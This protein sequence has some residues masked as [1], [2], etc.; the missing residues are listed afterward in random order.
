MALAGAAPPRRGDPLMLRRLTPRRQRTTAAWLVAVTSI[1][2]LD[3]HQAV[4]DAN[5]LYA[6]GKYEDAAAA[7]NAGLVDQPDSA[8]LHFNLGDA[9]YKQGKYEDS[10][11]SFQK[12]ETI[13]DPQRA[14]R[15]AYN[16]GN[17]SYRQGQAVEQTDPQKALTLYAEALAAYR[18]A[19][20]L[21]PNDEDSKFNHELV[22]KRIE[23]LKKKLAE[24][25]KEQEP[26]QDQQQPQDDQQDNQQDDQQKDQQK[27]Q[28]ED[29]QPKDD[30]QDE[31]PPQDQQQKDQQQADQDQKQ[32]E[33]PPA[34]GD[35]EDQPPPDQKQPAEPSADEQQ[36]AQQ[37]GENPPPEAVAGEPKDGELSKGEAAAILDSQRN[38]EVSPEDIIKKLQGARVAEPAQDW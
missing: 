9:T 4:R 26:K 11:S 12:V 31:Q 37:P 32:A 6:E 14:G 16:V 35:Q 25:K 17:A 34:G 5:R 22:T 23:D 10:V 38:E 7:Y 18:R 29:K 1:A 30:Q 27:D 24:Q 13:G 3:P 33:E 15:V 2:W 20:G 8:D 19:L 36:N 28:A 21:A